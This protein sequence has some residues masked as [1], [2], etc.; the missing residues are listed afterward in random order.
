M[1]RSTWDYWPRSLTD[2]IYRTIT[3]FGSTSQWILLSM[4]LVTSRRFCRTFRQYPATPNEQHRQALTLIRFGLFPL[5]SP[6][7]GEYLTVSFPPGTEM[8]HFPGLPS[9]LTPGFWSIASKRFSY[10]GICGSKA[11]CALPQLIAACH[12]LHRLYQPKPSTISSL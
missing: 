10:S 1:P 12:A 9:R 4:R 3:F 2:F 7:L 5:R 6:L 8:F 11:A